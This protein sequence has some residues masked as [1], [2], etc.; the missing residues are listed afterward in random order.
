MHHFYLNNSSKFKIISKKFILFLIITKNSFFFTFYF[1]KQII[2]LILTIRTKS[3]KISKKK[4]RKRN[5][6]FNCRINTFNWNT[7][8]NDIYLYSSSY[9]LIHALTRKSLPSTP[10]AIILHFVSLVAS[11]SEVILVIGPLKPD[12]EQFCSPVIIFHT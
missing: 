3:I 1:I 11:T 7:I 9:S 2:K 10:A 4:K 12:I 5:K 8:S 6:M